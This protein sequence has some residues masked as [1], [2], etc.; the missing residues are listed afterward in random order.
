MSIALITGS[1]KGI[2]LATAQALAK[3]GH[4]VIVSGRVE[5]DVN[6]ACESPQMEGLADGVRL[7][8][9]DPDSIRAAAEHIRD[10]HGKL[11]IL[12]NNAG[13]LP[14]ATDPEG[15]EFSSAEMFRKT[16]DTNVIGAV[17]VTEA[18]LPLLRSSAGGRIV[19]VSTR[20]GSLAEQCDPASPYYS[21]VVPAYQSS[22]A[23]LN[24]VTIGL[25]KKLADTNIVVSA[26]CPGFVQTDL[27]PIN[28]EQAPLTAEAA[29]TPIVAAA[30]LPA[31]SDSGTFVDANGPIAW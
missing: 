19:N 31:G 10:R 28:R 6:A 12:V 29:A 24:S 15:H 18:M 23:A 5:A 1:T 2:G 21:M 25:S 8:V 26:V 30:L 27:T 11:D 16:F 22:K 7:D 17:A 14:E 4:T 13:I 3:A 9:T 20:M